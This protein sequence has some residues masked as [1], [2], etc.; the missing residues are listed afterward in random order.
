MQLN[1][2]RN[3][4]LPLVFIHGSFANANS[5]R[6]II[7]NL[8]DDYH[9]LAIDLP[10]HGK[11]DD[12]DDFDN[13]TFNPEFNAISSALE[14]NSNH[15]NGIHLIGHSYGGVVAL[16]AAMT[17]EIPVRK[18]TLFEPVDA[19]V[20]PIFD[21]TEAMKTLLDFVEEYEQAIENGDIFA[22]AMVIDFWGGEGSFAMIPDHIK[23]AM[24]ARVNNS[25]LVSL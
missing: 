6:K 3:D 4:Q 19:A 18:L 1:P 22:C 12:P 2:D 8:K 7:E 9:C 20:L 13:P 15:S 11:M 23:P 21:E 17:S 25:L 24:A 16:A 5:W 10:G 14:N